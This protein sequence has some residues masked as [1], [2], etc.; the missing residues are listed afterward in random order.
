[1][2]LSSLLIPL[3]A[4][5]FPI[6]ALAVDDGQVNPPP[7]RIDTRAGPATLRRRGDF[8]RNCKELTLTAGVAKDQ[9]LT[10]KCSDGKKEKDGGKIICSTKRLKA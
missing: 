8:S 3:G 2:L 5:V 1:M 9:S 4:L 7:D 6:S 10:A